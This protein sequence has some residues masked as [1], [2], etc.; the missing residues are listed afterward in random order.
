MNQVKPID[1][2]SPKDT[3]TN[4]KRQL[5]ISPTPTPTPTPDKAKNRVNI[6]KERLR[7]RERETKMERERETETEKEWE[8]ER[9]RE[10]NTL[11]P[12][13]GGWRLRLRQWPSL[14]TDL[15]WGVTMCSRLRLDWSPMRS[16][17]V[18]WTAIGPIS[19]EERRCS[20]FRF[21]LAWFLI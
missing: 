16:N 7:W 20:V 9:K 4:A 17:D 3:N 12:E 2:F 14:T 1:C 5:I 13:E 15:R 6:N 8:T 21:A 10:R 11:I 18:L 19:D